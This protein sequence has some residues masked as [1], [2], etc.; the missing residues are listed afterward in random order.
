MATVMLAPSQALAFG[1][2]LLSA[3]AVDVVQKNQAGTVAKEGVGV[4]GDGTTTAS[5]LAHYLGIFKGPV[6][7]AHRPPV[8][9]VVDLNSA[10]AQVLPINQTDGAI[11]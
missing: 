7:I 2:V 6:I 3:V 4:C 1:Q 11:S 8:P 10:L 9:L 5:L